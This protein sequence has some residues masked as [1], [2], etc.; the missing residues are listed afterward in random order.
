MPYIRAESR[1]YRVEGGK[2]LSKGQ[3]CHVTDLFVDSI[4]HL[5]ESGDIS[6]HPA[7][8][9]KKNVV[10]PPSEKTAKAPAKSRR[11]KK[12]VSEE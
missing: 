10:K 7:D 8:P 11:K 4:K 9:N 1:S 2:F 5:V 6:V 12:I 3:T